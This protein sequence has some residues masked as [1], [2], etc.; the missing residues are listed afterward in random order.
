MR[1]THQLRAVRRAAAQLIGEDVVPMVDLRGLQ[2]RNG[3]ADIA[4]L[5]AKLL[6]FGDR[7]VEGVENLRESRAHLLPDRLAFRRVPP[8]DT[9][10]MLDL[11]GK[12]LERGRGG[13]F[14]GGGGHF[15]IFHNC[16]VPPAYR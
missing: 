5:L 9:E 3:L 4:E 10:K 16:A 8:L 6:V 11:P 2:A 15:G 14:G 1:L 13:V 12:G 7:A